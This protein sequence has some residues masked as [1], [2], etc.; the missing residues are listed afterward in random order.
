MMTDLEIAALRE[1]LLRN[2]NKILIKY[3]LKELQES[4]KELV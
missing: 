1:T 4:D 3:A 2:K